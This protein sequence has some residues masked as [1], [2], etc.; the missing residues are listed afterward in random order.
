MHASGGTLP[1]RQLA[2]DCPG[3]AYTRPLTATVERLELPAELRGTYVWASIS[4]SAGASAF[5]RCGDASVTVNP[6]A[7]ST[8]DGEAL[9]PAGTE[10]LVIVPPGRRV[11]FRTTPEW[12]HLAHISAGTGRL[13][14][15]GAP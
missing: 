12:T 11:R 10:P 7:L 15:G 14:I 9:T 13:H 8:L 2:D 6:A 1:A 3:S 4:P 5:L